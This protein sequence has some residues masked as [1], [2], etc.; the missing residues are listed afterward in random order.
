M[1]LMKGRPST[2]GDIAYVGIGRELRTG[3]ASEGGNEVVV[4]TTLMLI[5]GNSRTVAADVDEESSKKFDKSYLPGS[6][7][8][9]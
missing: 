1:V 5:G 8:D 6:I 3:S 4:G 2:S 9:P 7:S